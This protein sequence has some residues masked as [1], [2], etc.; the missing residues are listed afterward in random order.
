VQELCGLYCYCCCCWACC[1]CVCI[2]CRDCIRV[3]CG[4]NLLLLLLLLLLGMMA[5]L[6]YLVGGRFQ[7]L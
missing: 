5:L 4:V 1:I 6:D 7:L 2:A 3:L